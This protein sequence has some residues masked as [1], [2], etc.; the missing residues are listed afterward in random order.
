[1]ALEQLPRITSQS[2][3]VERVKYQ[4]SIGLPFIF[5]T[6][7]KESGKTVCS[8]L[9]I[10][11][12]DDKYQCAY[13]PCVDG[14]ALNKAREFLLRQLS[15]TTIFNADDRLIGTVQRIKFNSKVLIVVDS[16]DCLPENFLIELAEI[17][18][19][20]KSENLF[21]II[22]TSLPSWA[23][24]RAKV[25]KDVAITPIEMEISPL[26]VT[27]SLNIFL[28]YAR[29]YGLHKVDESK[30]KD[31]KEF[32]SCKGNPG[33]IRK[34]VDDILQQRKAQ[35]A[36]DSYADNVVSDVKDPNFD[37]SKSKKAFYKHKTVIAA[38]ISIVALGILSTVLFI[39]DNEDKIINE[40]NLVLD[41]SQIEDKML[42]ELMDYSEKEEVVKPKEKGEKVLVQQK[43]KE[44]D[45]L[46]TVEKPK[47]AEKQQ[48][49]TD[50]IVSV[51]KEPSKTEENS[52]N[53]T[54]GSSNIDGVNNT[55]TPEPIVVKASQ[56]EQNKQIDENKLTTRKEKILKEEKEENIEKIEVSKNIDIKTQKKNT[57]Q[58][59]K[60]E[61]NLRN[62]N[63][64]I[65]NKEEQKSKVVSN[66][67]VGDRDSF[68]ELNN[69]HY[70]IQIIATKKF[71]EANALAKTIKGSTWV[72]YRK[73]DNH[74][75]VMY[76]DFKNRSEA[77]RVMSTLPESIRKAGPWAKSIGAV[78]S[79]IK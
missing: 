20:Y 6:G 38:G 31:S 74:Y 39:S 75:I 63:K 12:S 79:E 71:S 21:S 51:Q 60:T 30:V 33:A 64:P 62:E 67:E 57:N 47:E 18:Q 8:E 35:L 25:F 9:I 58:V 76:G 11:A 22:V 34:L 66:A 36:K 28:Y 1:M 13:V 78:K 17:Y 10:S 16:I 2:T 27:D 37:T 61:E 44:Q 50:Y 15:P 14:M 73:R 24:I 46:K 72:L 53:D 69:N 77:S 5:I 23:D 40:P 32:K 7:D 68:N 42:P 43:V 41:D 19:A 56:P 4:L 45:E 48:T 65:A 55:K 70:S 26:N 29:C 54:D 52:K 59:V 3:L 49:L